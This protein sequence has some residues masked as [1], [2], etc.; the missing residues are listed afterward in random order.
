MEANL[1]EPT[2]VA[3]CIVSGH[4]LMNLSTN[5]PQRLSLCVD[6]RI[7]EILENMVPMRGG[8]VSSLAEWPIFCK[9]EN[10]N[11]RFFEA[12]IGIQT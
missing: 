3:E 6:F 11:P 5:L 4:L 1:C 10:G 8:G 7:L 12:E 9:A 2:R